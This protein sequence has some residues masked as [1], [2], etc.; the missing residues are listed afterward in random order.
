MAE[1]T[2]PEILA[3]QLTTTIVAARVGAAAGRPTGTE[4]AE[5]AQYYRAVLDEV[6]RGLGLPP[7]EG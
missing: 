3:S 6:R 1:Q 5:A 4:G 2:E 7:M